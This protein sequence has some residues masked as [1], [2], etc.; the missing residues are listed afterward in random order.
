MF[1]GLGIAVLRKE[2]GLSGIFVRQRLKAHSQRSLSARLKA[3]PDT[4]LQ[5]CIEWNNI[6]VSRFEKRE[7]C[8]TERE[9]DAPDKPTWVVRAR[10]DSLQGHGQY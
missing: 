2:S 5:D 7:T 10:E 6:V 9:S 4:N 3:R 8:G 1:G